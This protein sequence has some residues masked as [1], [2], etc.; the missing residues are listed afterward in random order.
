[1][2]ELLTIEDGINSKHFITL[3][4]D[5]SL[6]DVDLV[7]RDYLPTEKGDNPSSTYI[8]VELRLKKKTIDKIANLTGIECVDKNGKAQLPRH[9]AMGDITDSWELKATVYNARFLKNIK[10]N[11]RS[12]QDSK[13]KLVDEKINEA[14]EGWSREGD[15]LIA[16]AL[17]RMQ[18]DV[19]KYLDSNNENTTDAFRKIVVE[20]KVNDKWFDKNLSPKNKLAVEAIDTDIVKFKADIEKLEKALK[21]KE[22]EGYKIKRTTIEAAI[23]EE[24]GPL[25][26]ALLDEMAQE[27]KAEPIGMFHY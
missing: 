25:T 16:A 21:A 20:Q 14:K 7:Q 22:A 19:V 11:G 13:D 4:R 5:I 15:G 10:Y 3:S 1:M 23:L 6:E 27:E 26:K 12:S 24:S 18:E 9:G 17:R 2:S 8:G